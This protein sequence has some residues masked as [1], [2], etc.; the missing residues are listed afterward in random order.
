MGVATRRTSN[1]LYRSVHLAFVRSPSRGSPC[2]WR[3][4]APRR[5]PQRPAAPIG[6][7]PVQAADAA[8]RTGRDVAQPGSASHWGCGGR[9][10]ESSRPDQ[11]F[12]KPMNMPRWGDCAQL[13]GLQLPHCRL[14][15]VSTAA[16][17]LSLQPRRLKLACS[18]QGG[19]ACRNTEIQQSENCISSATN[20]H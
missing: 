13:T 6:A 9:R 12:H 18:A 15:G 16:K 10:F 20:G 19:A 8:G 11:Y 14:A 1:S 2:D 7:V 4:F 3:K 17:M 5:L